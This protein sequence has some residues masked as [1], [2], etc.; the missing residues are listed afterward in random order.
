MKRFA[1][2]VARRHFVSGHYGDRLC[3]TAM[4]IPVDP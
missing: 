4:L 2:I 1:T 3:G